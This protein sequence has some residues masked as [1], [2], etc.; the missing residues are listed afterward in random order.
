MSFKKGLL[1]AAF[2]LCACFLQAESGGKK[3]YPGANVVEQEIENHRLM[4]KSLQDLQ[5]SSDASVKANRKSF[6]ELMNYLNAALISFEY[7]DSLWA[8]KPGEAYKANE[9]EIK[10]A[11]LPCAC[12]GEGMCDA[13][14]GDGYV[15]FAEIKSKA[16]RCKRCKGSGKNEA[17]GNCSG[18]RGSGWANAHPTSP[19]VR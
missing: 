16:I 8:G 15:W 3:D 4:L 9:S 1:V 13:C 6:E 17:S 18:C 12:N 5:K 10:S 2:G 7:L 14:G 11:S 19:A